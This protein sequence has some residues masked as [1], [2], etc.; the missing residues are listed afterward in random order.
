MY[1]KRKHRATS[2]YPMFSGGEKNFCF[3][4]SVIGKCA[5]GTLTPLEIFVFLYYNPV[6]GFLTGLAQNLP[7]YLFL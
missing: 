6:I 3:T 7:F 4:F 2:C 1:I 5:N